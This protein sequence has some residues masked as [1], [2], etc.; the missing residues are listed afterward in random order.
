MNKYRAWQKYH[1][2]MCK[3]RSIDWEDDKIKA[4]IVEY[5]EEYKNIKQV[6]TIN[7]PTY[8]LYDKEGNMVFHL[9]QSTGLKDKNGVEI[10]EGDVVK[11]FWSDQIGE[12]YCTN[13]IMKNP[14]NYSVAESR[15][16]IHADELELLGNIH[17]NPEL[18]KEVE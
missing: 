4:L 9:M 14:F 17:A 2:A 15:H 5:P 3:V 10:F 16:L 1:K 13:I 11:Y 8:W 12:S 18:L 6:Y 7:S